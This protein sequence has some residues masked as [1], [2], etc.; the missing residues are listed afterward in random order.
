VTPV[1]A[2]GTAAPSPPP[3]EGPAFTPPLATLAAGP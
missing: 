3:D 2:R 1:T